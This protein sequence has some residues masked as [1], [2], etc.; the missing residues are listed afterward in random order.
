MSFFSNFSADVLLQKV[1]F[2]LFWKLLIQYFAI[3][4]LFLDQL[5]AAL[6]FCQVLRITASRS[7]KCGLEILGFPR[8]ICNVRKLSEPKK[9]RNLIQ[10]LN[11]PESRKVV[12]F[13]TN[14]IVSL[15]FLIDMLSPSTRSYLVASCL[16]PPP[17]VVAF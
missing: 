5:L 14:E 7:L 12:D 15:G 9:N 1:V 8:I 11:E 16:T 13:S 10:K 17:T 4:S 3:S 6:Y 2:F